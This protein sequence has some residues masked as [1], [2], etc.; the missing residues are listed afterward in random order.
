MTIEL[1][2]LRERAE[3]VAATLRRGETLVLSD[4]GRIATVSFGESPKDA[5]VANDERY[6]RAVQA[7][8]IIPASHRGAGKGLETLPKVE[9]G[10]RALLD[11]ILE[12]REEEDQEHGP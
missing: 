1:S 3:E 11:H 2:E 8:R 5:E 7:G 9:I 10:G 4:S 12:A 6:R